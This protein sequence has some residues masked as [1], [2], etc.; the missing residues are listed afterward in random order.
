MSSEL[1][2]VQ[3]TERLWDI[4]SAIARGTSFAQIGRQRGI[5]RERVRQL[6]GKMNLKGD[7]WRK[8]R[9]IKERRNVESERPAGLLGLIWD[10]A[11][12]RG[13]LIK[14]TWFNSGGIALRATKHRLLINGKL[15]FIC[16]ASTAVQTSE[17]C[18][19]R[20]GNHLLGAGDRDFQIIVNDVPGYQRRIFILPWSVLGA[21]GFYVPLEKLPA[22][23]NQHSTIDWWAYENAW[24]LIGESTVTL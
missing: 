15:C 3:A 24:R 5:S 9:K 11:S 1:G 19:R 16:K 13:L 21:K 17:G 22:Y 10:I 20:Y 6:A 4:G 12:A 18:R 8:A 7:D 23:N 14:R 2:T